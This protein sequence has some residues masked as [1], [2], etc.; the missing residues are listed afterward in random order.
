LLLLAFVA[1]NAVFVKKSASD[2][3][4]AVYA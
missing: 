3:N 2:P 4:L 1:V